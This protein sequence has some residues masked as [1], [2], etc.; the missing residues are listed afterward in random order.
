MCCSPREFSEDEDAEAKG[1]HGWCGPKKGLMLE[2]LA[3]EE[4]AF[5]S[6]TQ[7]WKDDDC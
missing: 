5:S 6:E 4:G 7:S 2:G 1:N 3:L